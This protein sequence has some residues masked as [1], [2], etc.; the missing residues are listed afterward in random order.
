MVLIVILVLLPFVLIIS[1]I[2][3]FNIYFRK[4]IKKDLDPAP[5]ID[6]AYLEAERTR[7]DDEDLGGG[8]EE[9]KKE[10]S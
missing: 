10:E 7:P 5:I 9:T 2:L 6:M 8:P 3:Y 4:Q 1:G